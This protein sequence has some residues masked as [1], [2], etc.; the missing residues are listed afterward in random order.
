MN[1]LT[2]QREFAANDDN[3]SVRGEAMPLPL[4]ATQSPFAA[5]DACR[6]DPPHRAPWP[7]EPTAPWYLRLGAAIGRLLEPRKPRYP[8]TEHLCRDIGLDWTPEKPVRTWP[9]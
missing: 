8:L 1:A 4:I 6:A 7:E 9:W 5:A 3:L 2:K